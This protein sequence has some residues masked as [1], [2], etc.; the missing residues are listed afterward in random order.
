MAEEKEVPCPLSWNHVGVKLGGVHHKYFL[1]DAVDNM[2]FFLLFFVQRVR[3][4]HDSQ[5]CLHV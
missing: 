2:N 1:Q 4:E 5:K 3:G